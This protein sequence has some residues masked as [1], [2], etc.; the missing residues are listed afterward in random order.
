MIPEVFTHNQ[1]VGGK[2]AESQAAKT[3]IYRVAGLDSIRFVFA[4]WLV[5]SHFWFIPLSDHL[6][7]NTAVMKIL[8][9][10]YNNLFCG[11]AEV[12]VFFVVSGFYIHFPFRYAPKMPAAFL[13]RRYLRI[14]LPFIFAFV[15]VLL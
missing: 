11:V 5:F 3:K 4:L 14:G 7:G 10:F 15:L 6:A 2:V 12:V 13:A 8:R 9:G 1:I